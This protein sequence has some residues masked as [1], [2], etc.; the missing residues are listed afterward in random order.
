ML[1]TTEVSTQFTTRVI[2]SRR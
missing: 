1:F 2:G